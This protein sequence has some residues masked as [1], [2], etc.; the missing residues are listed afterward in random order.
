M[1]MNLQE[2][3]DFF[4]LF[5]SDE[6]I[7][8]TDLAWLENWVNSFSYF[9]LAHWILCKKYQQLQAPNFDK[10]LKY[11]ASISHSRTV[12]QHYLQ[13]RLLPIDFSE[14]QGKAL[15]FVVEPLQKNTDTTI[16]PAINT[17]NISG[18]Y[19]IEALYPEEKRETLDE[20][21]SN[22]KNNHQKVQAIAEKKV[23][24][25]RKKKVDEEDLVSETLVKIYENQEN[26]LKAIEAYQALI[27][28]FPDK[29]LLY[30]EK[31]HELE[32]KNKT[33]E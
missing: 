27:K 14:H 26:W 10:S 31:I 32:Q 19:D 2:N 28:K 8:Q 7:K 9:P 12:L 1:V 4:S 3:K 5:F 25:P 11:T 18:A 23:R 13:D 15:E 20:W 16:K 21:L 17:Q 29:K 33:T 22:L 6:K 30:L 24:K